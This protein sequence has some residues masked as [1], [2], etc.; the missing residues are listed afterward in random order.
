MVESTARQKI[1]VLGLSFKPDTDDVRESPTLSL[2]ETL[3]GKGYQVSVYD[4]IIDPEKLIGVN[5]AFLERALPH[6]ASLIRGS[7]EEVIQEVDVVVI[8][9]GSPSFQRLPELLRVDQIIIDL[10]GIVKDHPYA[11]GNYEGICW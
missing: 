3:V 2:I 5:R 4:E 10:V 7:L 1:G 9:N 6:I 8:A 11:R